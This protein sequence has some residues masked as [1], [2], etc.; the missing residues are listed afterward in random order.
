MTEPRATIPFSFAGELTIGDVYRYVGR[1]VIVSHQFGL[2]R[3]NVD[4]GKFK[5]RIAVGYQ[6][7]QHPRS[8]TGI[9][10]ITD[11]NHSVTTLEANGAFIVTDVDAPIEGPDASAAVWNNDADLSFYGF[12]N[13]QAGYFWRPSTRAIIDGDQLYT[14]NDRGGYDQ[15]DLR[16]K[17]WTHKGVIP[18]VKAVQMTI[19]GFTY[20]ARG[21]DAR[22]YVLTRSDVAVTDPVPA[23]APVPV[24]STPPPPPIV[25]DPVPDVSQPCPEGQWRNPFTG[26]C[27]PAPVTTTP[28]PVPTTP[29]N[30]VD[31]ANG[32]SLR[33]FVNDTR[34]NLALARAIRLTGNT[35]AFHFG[36]PSN[37][38]VVA[39]V[40]DGRGVNGHYWVFA[41]GLTDVGCRLVAIKGAVK[42]EYVNPQGT[43]FRPI[44]D[45]AAFAA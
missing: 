2:V 8:D 42:K 37:L 41:A 17:V 21:V 24:P 30:A 18:P 40:L 31:F 34:I 27:E 35:V 39:K 20:V 14:R 6:N 19:D 1:D 7:P 32:V 9:Y 3:I 11:R 13:E 23:P 10:L 25:T 15:M 33:L 12:V 43:P 36:D 22:N 38:E 5:S 4:T 28:A 26:K 29:D 45:T 44:Q 16:R